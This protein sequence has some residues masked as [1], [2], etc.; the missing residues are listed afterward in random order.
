MP[1]EATLRIAQAQ[2][3][4]WLEGL[5]HGIQATLVAQQMAAHSFAFGGYGAAAC[6]RVSGFHG[7]LVSLVAVEGK[8]DKDLLVATLMPAPSGYARIDSAC[9]RQG[10]LYARKTF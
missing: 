6:G 9:L 2:L 5:F 10:T 4:G 1:S 3:V 7:V 8:G